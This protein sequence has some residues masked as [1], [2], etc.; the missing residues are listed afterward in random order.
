[1]GLEPTFELGLKG[2]TQDLRDPVSPTE[3]MNSIPEAAENHS[4][5][6]RGTPSSVHGMDHLGCRVE[7]DEGRGRT[8]GGCHGTRRGDGGPARV[9]RRGRLRTQVGP[10]RQDR[11]P[12]TV[13]CPLTTVPQPTKSHFSFGFSESPSPSLALCSSCCP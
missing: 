2:V 10:M 8:Y 13:F 11:W 6:G 12:C 1:M 3:E 7:A 4:A 9:E 5:Q